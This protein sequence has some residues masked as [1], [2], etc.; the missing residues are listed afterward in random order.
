MSQGSNAFSESLIKNVSGQQG[1]EKRVS[2]LIQGIIKAYKEA[3]STNDMGLVRLLNDDLTRTQSQLETLV[4]E[5][6]MRGTA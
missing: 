1:V 2:S 3:A 4:G 5:Q 6:S